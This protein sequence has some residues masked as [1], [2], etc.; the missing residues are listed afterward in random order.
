[1]RFGPIVLEPTLDSEGKD[2]FLVDI[3]YEGNG[4]LPDPKRV[5]TVMTSLRWDFVALGLPGADR[6]LHQHGGISGIAPTEAADALGYGRGRGSDLN[7]RHLIDAARI[8]AGESGVGYLLL[9]QVKNTRIPTPQW[10]KQPYSMQH[11]RR[12]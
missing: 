2:T 1:M 6:V 5:I 4:E 12:H 11:L 3:V 7:W 10:R 9:T 8:L